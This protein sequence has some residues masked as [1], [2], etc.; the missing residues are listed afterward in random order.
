M[1]KLDL[2]TENI[3]KSIMKNKIISIIEDNLVL[4]SEEEIIVD[5]SP[6]E[7]E[8]CGKPKYINDLPGDLR[9]NDAEVLFKR[10]DAIKKN[11]TRTMEELLQ[12]DNVFF[13]DER[14]NIT[15]KGLAD[16]DKQHF[17]EYKGLMEEVSGYLDY[18][19][20]LE[21]SED[22]KYQSRIG[23]NPFE[24]HNE[25]LSIRQHLFTSNK[26]FKEDL[27][28]LTEKNLTDRLQLVE[29]RGSFLSQQFDRHH[30]NM[31]SLINDLPKLYEGEEFNKNY[32]AFKNVVNK[33][34]TMDKTIDDEVDAVLNKF[35]KRQDEL[36]KMNKDYLEESF[37]ISNK[38]RELGVDDPSDDWI[39]MDEFYSYYNPDYD[40]SRQ[41][42][43]ISILPTEFD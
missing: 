6:V 28:K 11:M 27:S 29:G 23:G 19:D 26:R 17:D 40:S 34:K 14:Y 10:N 42:R 9:S 8:K 22:A 38:L 2:I 7:E 1:V 39:D 24:G 18:F 20:S 4:K 12:R 31:D 37:R 30:E 13:D 3:E 5:E 41:I 33:L 43:D 35:D 16:I 32:D 21:L 36:R 15:V 25:I